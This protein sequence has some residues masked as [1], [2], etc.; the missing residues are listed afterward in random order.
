[1]NFYVQAAL[2]QLQVAVHSTIQILDQLTEEDLALQPIA[3][4]R[5]I[6]D[7]L[8]HMALICQ[9]DLL[10]SG[11][12]S[13]AEMEA[14]YGK[15]ELATRD[16][17][18]RTLLEGQQELAATYMAYTE[19]ELGEKAVAYWGV[20]YTRYEWLLEIVVHMYHHRA[21]LYTILT[22]HVRDLKVTL[23]E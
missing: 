7:Q 11:E 21:Q 17:I 5:S 16:E 4:K 3:G 1:M 13:Q 15:H 9:A 12:A 6:R 18:R 10:I 8:A 2:H 22:E 20:A 14:F 19:Q 23:F